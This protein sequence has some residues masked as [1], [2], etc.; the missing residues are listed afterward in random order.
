[1]QNLEGWEFAASFLPLNLYV[2]YVCSGRPFLA[3]LY[4]FLE[5]GF[6]ALKYRF[7]ATVR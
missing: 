4:Y 5:A 6:L 7:D 2:V 1:M 3:E